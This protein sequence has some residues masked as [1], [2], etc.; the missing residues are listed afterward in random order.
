M[1]ELTCHSPD[2]TRPIYDHPLEDCTFENLPISTHWQSR[3]ASLEVPAY[4]QTDTHSVQQ[5]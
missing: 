5:A 4:M 1:L 2:Y 3:Y